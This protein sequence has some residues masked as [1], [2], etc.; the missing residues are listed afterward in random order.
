MLSLLD[1]VAPLLALSAA[2]GCRPIRQRAVPAMHRL[3]GRAE[4]MPRGRG[5]ASQAAP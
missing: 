5:A 3:A 4:V 2:F 1:A